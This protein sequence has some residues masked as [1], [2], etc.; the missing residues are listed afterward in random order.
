MNKL[1]FKYSLFLLSSLFF[2]AGCKTTK[3]LTPVAEQ[4]PVTQAQVADTIQKE[5]NSAFLFSKM[6]ENQFRFNRLIIKYSA[7]YINNGEKT[8]FSG[9]IRLLKD[10]LIWI[11]ISKFS[12]E[13]ARLLIT[14]DSI[15]FLNRMEENWMATDFSYINRFANNA[16]DFDMLQAFI[17]GN[18]FSYY[19]T[20]KFKASM[21][22]DEYKLSTVNRHKLKK[23]VRNQNDMLR[24]LVQTLTLDPNTFKIKDVMVKEVK[25]NKKMRAEYLDY[26]QIGNQLFPGKINVS[27]HAEKEIKLNLEY[28]KVTLDEETNFP[29]KI[30]SSYQRVFIN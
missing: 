13:G 21:N 20:D 1:I 2:I 3:Q 23:Y 15:W 4:K 24:I 6:K 11:S 29:F 18:D 26:Q 10:S 30:P 25:E 8:S 17:A 22:G 5:A 7:D 16:V 19:E 27:L 14:N 28:N 12:I 9:Q